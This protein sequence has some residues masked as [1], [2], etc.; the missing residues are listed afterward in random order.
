MKKIVF[1]NI[2]VIFLWIFIPLLTIA[3]E[4]DI[5]KPY[6]SCIDKAGYLYTANPFK[7]QIHKF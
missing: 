5:Y 7:S 4:L 6:G 3:A 2:T 1:A